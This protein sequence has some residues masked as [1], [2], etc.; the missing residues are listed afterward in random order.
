MSVRIL[1]ASQ[2]SADAISS[3]SVASREL[4]ESS[5]GVGLCRPR[6]SKP[7]VG[8]A[9]HFASDS[10][11]ATSL[12]TASSRSL[13]LMGFN[14]VLTL[15]TELTR[16]CSSMSWYGSPKRII[17]ASGCKPVMNSFASST[18]STSTN[19]MGAPRLPAWR[20]FASTS[21]SDVTVT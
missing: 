18:L 16:L 2:L 9:F 17:P 5:I 8:S 19:T 14:T 12:F 13:G 10:S 21:F 15:C 6:A 7:G 3:F 1:F 4:L 11:A 20:T